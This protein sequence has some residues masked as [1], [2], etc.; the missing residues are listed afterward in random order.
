MELSKSIITVVK[1]A[2]CKLT[3]PQRREFL[4]ETTIELLDGS[5][6]KAERIFGWGRETVKLGLKEL[7]S[8]I[9][10]V[11]NY[12]ARGNKKTEEKSSQL[13]QDIRELVE[14]FSQADPDFK[15]P[16]AYVK[17]TAKTLRQALIDEKGYCNEEL[18]AERTFFDILNR[19][20]YT[21]KRVEKTK[22]I[23]K[24]QKLMTFLKMSTKSIKNQMTIPNL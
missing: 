22:P 10:C 21:L 18:P 2:A 11:D 5:P 16:F 1:N 24:F 3:G 9:T 14:P 17:L 8:G 15:R 4:A 23:K 6:N 7:T 13:E 20:G 19:L 12:T